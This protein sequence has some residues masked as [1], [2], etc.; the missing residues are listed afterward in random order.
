MLLLV[1]PWVEWQRQYLPLGLVRLVPVGGFFADIVAEV[2][3]EQLL[4]TR[5]KIFEHNINDSQ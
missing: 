5:G 2:I 3:D 1:Q 4:K